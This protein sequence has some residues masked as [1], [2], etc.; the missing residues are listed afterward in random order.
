MSLIQ[1]NN[2]TVP[3][4]NLLE[5]EKVVRMVN[6]IKT[7]QCLVDR[8]LITCD[9]PDAADNLGK[10]AAPLLVKYAIENDK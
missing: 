2:L 6:T 7:G 1:I 10:L 4:K 9:S 5:G 8:E 3:K